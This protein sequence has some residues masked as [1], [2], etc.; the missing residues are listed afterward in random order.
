MARGKQFKR[1]H[2]Q[3]DS[4]SN[5]CTKNQTK[6]TKLGE[7]PG[8]SSS[9]TSSPTPTPTATPTPPRK[10][11]VILEGIKQICF[12]NPLKL[13]RELKA[14]NPLIKKC[15][16]KPGR[17]NTLIVCPDEPGDINKLLE[18]WTSHPEL[19]EI[20][21]RLPA[22]KKPLDEQI[23]IKNV[24]TGLSEEE[25][26][27]ALSEQGYTVAEVIRFRKRNQLVEGAFIV[28]KVCKISIA[29]AEQAA[30]IL[31]QGFKLGYLQISCERYQV[32]QSE[33]C[34]NCQRFGHDHT[35]CKAT[36]SCRWC[37]GSHDSRTCPD[38]DGLKKCSNCKGG[39]PSHY[40]GCPARSKYQELKNP[41]P[42]PSMTPAT[43]SENRTPSKTTKPTPTPS[44][45][46]TPPTPR[47]ACPHK[48]VS[49]KVANTLM[50][51]LYDYAQ[52]LGLPID[53][54][55]LKAL[56]SE[57]FNRC[58]GTNFRVESKPT[59]T[60]SEDLHLSDSDREGD[61]TIA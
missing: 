26:A 35:R 34:F 7:Q 22:Q 32:K 25:I 39:H 14:H 30:R 1:T 46:A 52:I 6:K 37:S 21:P 5:K 28:M 43:T 18:D 50:Y 51:I 33:Q 23:I 4:D 61:S 48:D 16:L 38:K 59:Q 45:P 56:I 44:K 17:N 20:K 42:T 54:T 10:P 3:S 47:L 12:D 58:W 15:S 2:A 31:E 49:A 60:L 29:D 36:P 55:I 9:S 8:T 27:E 11:V 13:D 24:P 53:T 40:S 57:G 41:T 19:G